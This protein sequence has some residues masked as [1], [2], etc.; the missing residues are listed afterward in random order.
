M[1]KNAENVKFSEYCRTCAIESKD[2]R[3]LYEVNKNGKTIAELIELCAQFSLNENEIRP[4]NICKNC[5]VMLNTAFEFYN[6]V[7]SSEQRLLGND[8]TLDIKKEETK[9]LPFSMEDQVENIFVEEPNVI[10]SCNENEE[11]SVTVDSSDIER[12]VRKRRK[13]TRKSVGVKK[14]H[15]KSGRAVINNLASTDFECYKCKQSFSSIHK[16]NEHFKDHEITSKCRICLKKCTRCE[17]FQHLCQ[18]AKIDCQYCQKSFSTTPSLIKHINRNHKSHKNYKCYD[19][20]KSFHTKL[21]LEIHKPTHDT[22]EKRFVCDLCQSRFR[23]RFQI[24]EH[25]ELTH[26]DKRSFLCSTCGKSFKNPTYLRAHV[27]RHTS[28]KSVACPKCPKRFFDKH[29]LKKHIE[30]HDD[31]RFVCDICGSV[32]RSR[33]SYM[34]HKR[35]HKKT[36]VFTCEVCNKQIK[37]SLYNLR[38]HMYTHTGEKPFKCSYCDRRYTQN[39]DLN[40]HLRTHVG[41]NTYKCNLCDKSYRLLGELRR[42][43]SE[44]YQQNS[45]EKND[46][47]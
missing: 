24:K 11:Q 34:E 7:R 40:K 9:Q 32:M 46:F 43:T 33:G 28:T 44:H 15:T 14:V 8:E 5:V 17:Y 23:T 22:E 37:T 12:S 19:C 42:H 25:M 3:S 26:T 29:G 35:R 30:V 1:D 16:V 38:L 27:K 6:L 45:I 21:L 20:A 41:Q 39:A 47:Q 10:L 36:K 2:L 13:R 31:G 4:K 18:G